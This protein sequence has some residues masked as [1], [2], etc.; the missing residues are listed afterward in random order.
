MGFRKPDLLGAEQAIRI[1][2]TEIRSPYNDG[3]TSAYIKLELYQLKCLLEDLYQDLP[4]F[5]DEESW[6][7]LRT[8]ELLKKK[9]RHGKD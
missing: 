1:A 6:E 9:E 7:K 4:K 5:G 2:V 8:M 3:F